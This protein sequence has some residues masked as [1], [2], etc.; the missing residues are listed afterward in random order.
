MNGIVISYEFDGDEAEWVALVGAFVAALNAD[1]ELNGGFSY[2]VSK[3]K[4]SPKRTHMG[5]WES[6]EVLELM[7]SR[8]YFKEF[9]TKLKAMAGDSLTPDGMVV[10]TQTANA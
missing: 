2:V 7:Q 10:V 8:E 5:R 6:Q 1:D 3:S 4:N 9:S